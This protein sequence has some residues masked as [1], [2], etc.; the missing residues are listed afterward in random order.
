MTPNAN[1]QQKPNYSTRSFDF[2]ELTNRATI[3]HTAPVGANH[4]Q[5]A[6]FWDCY[7]HIWRQ[8]R[9]HDAGGFFSSVDYASGFMPGMRGL[10]NGVNRNKRIAYQIGVNSTR[11]LL[12]NVKTESGEL[13][14]TAINVMG[15]TAQNPLARLPHIPLLFPKAGK[16]RKSTADLVYESTPTGLI[17]HH[18]NTPVAWIYPGYHQGQIDGKPTTSKFVDVAYHRR[19]EH[20]VNLETRDFDTMQQA[21]DFITATFGQGGAK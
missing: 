16:K 1:Q 9:Q 14:M 17:V 11:Q 6:K 7:T 2:L 21:V 18:E 13:A 5:T 20:G 15:N 4:Q 19:T 8:H 3:R 12:P 10:Q